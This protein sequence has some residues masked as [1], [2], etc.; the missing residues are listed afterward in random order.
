[1]LLHHIYT[2]DIFSFFK[3][4]CPSKVAIS[5]IL[6]ALKVLTKGK[7]ACPH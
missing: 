3:S 5:V 7:Q 6:L 2:G 4:F 1:M